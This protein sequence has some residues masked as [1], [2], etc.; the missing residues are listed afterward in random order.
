M[1]GKPHQVRVKRSSFDQPAN[2]DEE[3]GE[4]REEGRSMLPGE[5]KRKE[6]V[7]GRKGR[8]LLFQTARQE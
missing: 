1:A 7:R 5:S 3:E 8:G 2:I 6:N 4:R